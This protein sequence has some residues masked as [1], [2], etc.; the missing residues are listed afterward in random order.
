MLEEFKSF[1]KKEFDM[2][3][4]GRMR[5]F[6]GI[7]VTQRDDG[8]FISQKKY[9]AEVIDRFGMQGFNSVSNPIVPG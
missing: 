5:Y 2:I 9:A 4:L 8:I 1:M 3:V 6:L 7:E